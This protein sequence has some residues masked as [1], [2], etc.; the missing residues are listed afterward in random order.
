MSGL[1]ATLQQGLRGYN[2]GEKV[3]ALRLRKKMRLV[4][5]GEHTG[6]SAA[7]LSKIESGK[8]FPTLPT[9]MR[10]SLVFNLGLEHFFAEDK[11]KQSVGL[12][13]KAD[14][15]RLA[16]PPGAKDPQHCFEVLTFAATDPKVNGYLADFAIQEPTKARP[17]THSGCEFLYVTEGRLQLTIGKE[18]HTLEAGDAIYFDSSLPHSYCRVAPDRCEA[19]VV[20]A[21]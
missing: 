21:L 6:L 16:E 20:T 15:I 19:L 12:V 9:L 17:H 14:R 13:R 8:L 4:E 5:L 7:M 18:Q 3:R 1:S 2:I 10:I 11:R